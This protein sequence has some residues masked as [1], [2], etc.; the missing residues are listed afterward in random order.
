MAT[1][2]KQKFALPQWDAPAHFV[3]LDV[4][5]TPQAAQMGVGMLRARDGEML[6]NAVFMPDNMADNPRGTIVLMTGYSE[7]I[8]KYFETVSDLLALGY[9]VVMP[10][11]R[12]HGLSDGRGA[13][14]SRLHLTDFDV[15]LR[16]LE[17]RWEKLVAPMPKPHLG[18]A[19]SMGGQISMRAAHAHPDWF[20]ALAQ[21]APMYGI[22]VPWHLRLLIRLIIWVQK[23]RGQLD[24]W[25]PGQ[26]VAQRPAPMS[27]NRITHDEARF[28]RGEALYASEPKLQVNGRSVAWVD[29]VVRVMPKTLKPAFLR[30]V[31]TPLFIASAADEMLVD[32]AAHEKVLRHLP[33]GQGK[34]YPHARHE[35]MM[36]KDATR[37]AFLADVEAFYKSVIG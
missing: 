2:T 15:Y 4:N 6:R 22:P 18:L 12:G 35:L 27:E 37:Q 28:H 33:H 24:V 20:A 19:H 36:E 21:C 34:T 32:N 10:E 14:T 23:L 25:M 1:D 26:P 16:D 31:T 5:P 13:D 30:Q 8:E 3:E 17:D 9:A 11:W 29:S 7:F